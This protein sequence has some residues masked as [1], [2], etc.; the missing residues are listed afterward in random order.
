[1][2]S[3]ITFWCKARRWCVLNAH[4]QSEKI[5]GKFPQMYIGG[6]RQLLHQ[7][8][9]FLLFICQVES[10]S[11]APTSLS[12]V[13]PTAKATERRGSEF[14][15][16]TE[17]TAMWTALPPG[18][19]DSTTCC[20][21]CLCCSIV[22]SSRRRAQIQMP[23]SV[24]NTNDNSVSRTDSTQSELHYNSTLIWQ[25]YLSLYVKVTAHGRACATRCYW[26]THTLLDWLSST[27]V[28]AFFN[29]FHLA[30]NPRS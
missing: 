8:L 19:Q 1:M 24:C 26:I 15:A 22:F 13:R 21:F 16:A 29:G 23:T 12:A 27:Q 30:N 28:D 17:T 5:S 11:R 4:R 3:Q 9:L 10:W 14:T 20:R 7:R 2:F 25:M 6:S 18:C